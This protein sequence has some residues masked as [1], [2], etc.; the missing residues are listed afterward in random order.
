MKLLPLLLIALL[1]EDVFSDT[2]HTEPV[3][4]VSE[5]SA[6][7]YHLDWNGSLGNTY[8]VEY[9]SDL[10]TWHYMPVVKSGAGEALQYDFSSFK[11][12]LYMRLRYTD[13]PTS[14]AEQADFDGDSITNW[15]E[16]RNGG[17]GTNPFV[18]DSDGN[19]ILDAA[20]DRDGDGS[21]DALE[22]AAGT[23][24]NDASEG[25]RND[26]DVDSDNDG[27]MNALDAV[28]DDPEINWLR[29]PE[30]SYAWIEIADLSPT[31]VNGGNRV[32]NGDQGYP[33]AVNKHAQ[34]LFTGDV[35]SVS[36]SDW[37]GL[38]KSGS[39]PVTFTPNGM[40]P[41]QSLNFTQELSKCLDINDNGDILGLSGEFP[42]ELVYS[43]GMIWQ[44]MGSSYSQYNMPTYFLRTTNIEYLEDG[45]WSL[46]GLANDGSIQC[47][48]MG[49]LNTFSV[50]QTGN[51][52]S[53]YKN[54]QGGDVYIPSAPLDSQRGIAWKYNSGNHQLLLR[55]GASLTPVGTPIQKSASTHIPSTISVIPPTN[56]LDGT[57]QSERLWIASGNEIYL[58]KSKATPTARWYHPPS[59]NKPVKRLNER[60]E[61]LSD[62]EL[63][64]N[65][66]YISLTQI[67][68]SAVSTEQ[69]ENLK[70]IDLASNG[71]ILIQV[72][73]DGVNKVGI[74][75][76]VE[77]LELSPKLLDEN[78]NEIAGSEKPS[79]ASQSTEMVERDPTATPTAFNNASAIRIAWRDMKVNV[80]K[81]LTGK[82]ITWSMT[83]QFTPMKADGTPEPTP[84]FRGA[85]GTAINPVHRHQFSASEKY[86]SHDY[87]SIT[88][89][90]E[91]DTNAGVTITA[92]TTVDVHGYTAVRVNLPPV[93]FNKS[94]IKIRIE[95]SSAEID[96]IELEVPAV[97]VVDAGH[98][99]VLP[100]NDDD[101]LAEGYLW[102]SSGGE[103]RLG[104][105]ATNHAEGNPS[106]T[107][108]K[109]MT[110]DFSRLLR[111]Q[112]M[113]LRARQDL[114]LKV[115]MTRNA[116]ENLTLASR[117]RYAR[118][119]GADQLLSIHFNGYNQSARGVEV[120]LDKTGNLNELA[121]KA[122]G[123]RVVD[124]AY[125]A[126]Y[127]FDHA[128]SNRGVK[129]DQGLDVISDPDLGNTTTYQFCRAALLEVEFIDVPMVDQL[130]NTGVNH[131]EVR[132]AVMKSVADAL[133]L[134]IRIQPAQ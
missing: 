82:K 108:E 39:L 128:A 16:I 7:H 58:E 54:A 36:T 10:K 113:Q 118:D 86:G 55:E 66:T 115:K 41:S 33:V 6:D 78:E 53:I 52:M 59:M 93:G 117:A 8:F 92:Q 107:L 50:G 23:D 134:D 62:N 129:I 119:Y 70:S 105:S 87:E 51:T 131:E 9:S 90:L 1:S 31:S 85:W 32:L 103:W 101:K 95:D 5:L 57:Q 89:M 27:L 67:L 20:E 121:D 74:L 2:H 69:I 111:D 18:S 130:L 88:Q 11:K 21:S 25:G 68:K 98:G 64:R 40:P 73:V 109:T 60:G 46:G 47:G 102:S 26:V 116:D 37:I 45:V 81:S 28:H 96:L 80:G 12:K 30:A 3:L 19:G 56:N 99:G 15:D 35:W 77:V 112:I 106:N 65:G 94:Q 71:T 84:R 76:P 83:P 126:L 72:E 97:I 61:G 44:R 114:R 100:G 22:L 122:L 43:A 75:L 104:G 13:D 110:L 17:L 38:Q 124:S 123:Q 4:L 91:A 29:T 48:S 42:D 125:R 24:F 127:D 79:I 63:W 14:D 133:L 120:Q 49:D 34:V 132:K